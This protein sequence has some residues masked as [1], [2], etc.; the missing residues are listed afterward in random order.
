[1]LVIDNTTYI[2]A[3]K[4]QHIIYVNK[5]VVQKIKYFYILFELQIGFV[6]L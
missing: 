5:F 3:W 4:N 6:L 1:M 2:P